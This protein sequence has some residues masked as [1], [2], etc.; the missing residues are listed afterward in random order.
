MIRRSG[1]VGA[2]LLALAAAPAPGQDAYP[3]NHTT[4]AP[5]WIAPEDRL[6]FFTKVGQ[7]LGLSALS[8]VYVMDMYLIRDADDPHD[9][10]CGHAIR[11]KDARVMTFVVTN[12]ATYLDVPD[13]S[14]ATLG[15]R[16]PGGL[17]L[18]WHARNDGTGSMEI[19]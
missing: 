14:L 15:C 9:T 8:D 1:A 12:T 11:G 2:V 7:L 6:D 17:N 16:T 3:P 10:I 5:V 19:R 4:S 13:M 18:A